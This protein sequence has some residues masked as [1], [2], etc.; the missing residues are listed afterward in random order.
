MKIRIETDYIWDD[1]SDKQREQ[2]VIELIMTAPD[3]QEFQNKII[4]KL[5]KLNID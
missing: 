5:N 1:L 4:K 3:A 2:L